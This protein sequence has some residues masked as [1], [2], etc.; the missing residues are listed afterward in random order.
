M[1]NLCARREYCR[2]DI[3]EKTL[4]ASGG[5]AGLADEIVASLIKEKYVDDSRYAS[6]FAREKSAIS[7]WGPLK[8]RFA[9]R[10][11]R[12]GE[13]DIRQALEEA[14]TEK[15][16]GKLGKA[17]EAK[18][19]TLCEDPQGKLKLIRF[20]LGRGYEYDKIKDLVEKISSGQSI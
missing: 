5:D 12:I 17:L 16:D 11:K 7:G 14:D 4:K 1:E 10:S 15:A 9:L 2:S 20:A 6:A 18:W 3:Y 8:I 19:K 13:D